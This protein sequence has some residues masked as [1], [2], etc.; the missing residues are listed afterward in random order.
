MSL[1]SFVVL[2]LF[3]RNLPFEVL[4][5]LEDHHILRILLLGLVSVQTLLG[6][7]RGASTLN[8]SLRGSED[9][10]S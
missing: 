10:L 8:E 7:V 1:F 4:S 3:Q 5:H 6:E 2:Y 9:L